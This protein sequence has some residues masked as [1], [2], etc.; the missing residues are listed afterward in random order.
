MS[1]EQ[2]LPRTVA[3]ARDAAERLGWGFRVLDAEY[4]HLFEVDDGTRRRVMIGALS[5]LNDSVASRLAADKYFTAK[6]LERAGL[7]VPAT[8]RCLAPGF[9]SK[10]S[11]EESAGPEPGLEFARRHGYPVVVKPIRGSS[12]QHVVLA[13]DDEQLL[14]ALEPAWERHGV[15]V[16]QEPMPTPDLRLD[17]LDGEYLLGYERAPIRVTGDGHSTIRQLVARRDRRFAADATWQGRRAA[18]WPD[19]DGRTPESVLPAGE[20]LDLG[21][22]LLNLNT[23]ASGRLIP[24]LPRPWLEY[25]LRAGAVLGLRHFGIDFRGAGLADPP[26]GSAIVEINSSPLLL[27]IHSLGWTDQAIEAQVKILRAALA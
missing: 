4:G 23:W 12:G 19:A 9:F 6:L 27:Q 11:Y 24:E 10:E 17:F 1:G 20:P 22:T 16:V 3:L 7:R 2:R 5:P 18:A 14:A 26:R 13:H 15:A 21:G 8:E 25:G